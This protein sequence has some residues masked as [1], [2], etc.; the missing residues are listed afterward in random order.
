MGEGEHRCCRRGFFF[1]F[2]SCPRKRAMEELRRVVSDWVYVVV[3]GDERR[4]MTSNGLSFFTR[5]R[6]SALWS[7]DENGASLFIVE[8]GPFPSAP[9]PERQRENATVQEESS[10]ARTADGARNPLSRSPRRTSSGA[11]FSPLSNFRQPNPPRGEKEKINKNV[12][13]GRGLFFFFHRCASRCRA[14]E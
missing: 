9:P 5:P 12:T 3:C 4:E 6:C 10:Y 13:E 2:C 11:R 14:G 7:I 8:S 1:S